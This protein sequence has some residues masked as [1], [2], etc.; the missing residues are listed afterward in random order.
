V[1]PPQL[2]SSV[3]VDDEIISVK[4]HYLGRFRRSQRG[5]FEFEIWCADYAL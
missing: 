5:Q 1:T 4:A 2:A 3:P